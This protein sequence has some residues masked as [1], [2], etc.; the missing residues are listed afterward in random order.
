M[1]ARM[2][3]LEID[4]SNKEENKQRSK[5]N[6]NTEEDKESQTII[7]MAMASGALFYLLQVCKLFVFPPT[8]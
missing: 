8:F 7:L 2:S 6:T 4:T 3:S 5:N 1:L